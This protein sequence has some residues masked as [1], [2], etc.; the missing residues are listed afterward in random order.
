MGKK[1]EDEHEAL[2]E[3]RKLVQ[4]LPQETPAEV[5]LRTIVE[6][7]LY[8]VICANEKGKITFWNSGAE[9]LFGWGQ[10]ILG[11]PIETIIPEH[12][13]EMH[14]KGFEHYL[15]TGEGALMGRTTKSVGLHKSGLLFAI[16]IALS[17][18]GPSGLREF[19]TLIK[20][21]G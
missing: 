14:R 16:E 9:H 17:A 19:V 4:R 3:L 20:R 11:Q 12:L 10:E 8:A 15:S 7:M 2:T 5:R 21:D 6:A 18:T 13:R 1:Y